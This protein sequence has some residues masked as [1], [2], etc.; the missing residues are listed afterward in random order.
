MNQQILIAVISST[1]I[2]G[3]FVA[4]IS[5]LFNL[6]TKHNEYVN[7]YYKSVIQRRLHA[8]EILEFVIRGYKTTILNAKNQPYYIVFDEDDNWQNAYG[9][10]VEAMSNALWLGDEIFELTKELNSLIFRLPT[11]TSGI[12]QFGIDN[13][14]EMAQIRD[15]LEK[16]L[17]IDM[18]DLHKV[19]KFL[20]LKKNKKHG[21]HEVNLA[22]VILGRH[23]PAKVDIP[24]KY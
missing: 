24:N 12:T 5:G 17:A 20:K 8:Y 13:Y 9:P 3:M 2:S 14:I 7:D 10:L 18:L 23:N 15:A 1:L 19:E 4:A 11:M 22:N 16:Q 21:F 6:R